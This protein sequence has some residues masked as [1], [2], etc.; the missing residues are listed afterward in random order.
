MISLKKCFLLSSAIV[1]TLGGNAALADYTLKVNKNDNRG[2]WEGWGTSLAW[3]GKGVGGSNYQNTYADLLFT[4]NDVQFNSTV[5]PGLGLNIARYNI[6]G[7]GIPGENI[8][9]TVENLPSNMPWYKDIDGF[10]KDWKNLDVNSSSWDWSRDANQRNFMLAARD[11][12]A[13]FEF[14]ANAP[15]WWMTWEKSSAGGALQSWNHRDFARYLAKTTA[16]AQNNWGITVDSLEPFNE[17]LA[18]WWNYPKEQEG[19]NISQD[20]QKEILGY[21][22]EE[23]IAEGLGNMTIAAADENTMNQAISTYNYYKSHNVS[24]NGANTNLASLVG[25]VNVH[26]YNGL[27]PWRD[28]GARQNL[29]STVGS[30][31]IWVSEYGDNDGDGLTLAQTITEDLTYLKPSAWIYWQ[32]VEAYNSWG[33]VNGA[34]ANASDENANTRAMPGWIYNKYYVFAQFTRFLRPGYKIIGSDDHNTITAYDEVAKKLLFIT[35][36]YGNAQKIVYDFSTLR[37]ATGKKATITFT[38]NSGAKRLQ[39]MTATVTSKK[40]SINAEANTVYSTIVE[41]VTL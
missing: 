38:N 8:D 19:V 18:G 21:L 9:G 11:R 2:V 30:K 34:F 20:V 37:S 25:K 39:G 6:G 1:L 22:K 27:S 33:F 4:L 24:I 28:N 3:L 23:L 36:N 16:Y 26:S 12:G 40:F 31:R 14:F 10:W 7:G 15:M 13:R 17:P 35:V 29:R 41:G 5:L 32:A